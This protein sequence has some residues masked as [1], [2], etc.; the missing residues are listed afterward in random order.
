[1]DVIGLGILVA[2]VIVKSVTSFP[3][4]GKLKTVDSITVSLGGCAAN[5][6]VGLSRLGFET[7][8]MGV[9]GDDGFGDFIIDALTDEG[10]DPTGVVHI[11]N[12]ATSVTTVLVSPDGDRS[13]LHFKGANA[14][15]VSD[16]LDLD[17]LERSRHI[18]MAGT[19]LMDA[20]DGEDAASVLR[21]AKEAGLTTSLDTAWDD[22]GRW[23]GLVEPMFDYIDIFLPSVEEA[24]MMSG[25]DS[26]RE[27][28]RF[29]L[30]KGVK[31]VGIKQ[32][33]DGGYFMREGE[34]IIHPAL[35]VDVIDTTGCGDAFCA[36][37]IAGY[38]DGLPMK[39]CGRMA[40]TTGSLC[41]TGIG[42]TC[43]LPSREQLEG[44]LKGPDD[45]K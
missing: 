37:F 31:I 5:T 29:F 14:L 43:A 18:H 36:G 8:V 11:E 30:A 45:V 23:W 26:V 13:F 10:I 19:F 1:M 21:T 2:D 9:V 33:A 39:E 7:L 6:A 25:E 22:S 3:E 24:R 42:A 40:V 20:F 15:F 32:G 17:F 12:A 38:L 28:A 44:K 27:M 41:A 35:K 16:D 4:L 34:E